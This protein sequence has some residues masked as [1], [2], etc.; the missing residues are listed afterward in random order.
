MTG[1]MP[2]ISDDGITVH[3]CGRHSHEDF[4]RSIEFGAML[5]QTLCP[6]GGQVAIKTLQLTLNTQGN[7]LFR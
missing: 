7:Y 2:L 6:S 4:L 1:L 3:D 5:E